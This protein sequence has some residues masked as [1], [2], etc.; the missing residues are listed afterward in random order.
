MNNENQVNNVSTLHF[1]IVL[2]EHRSA[3]VVIIHLIHGQDNYKEKR[4]VITERG[5]HNNALFKIPQQVKIID[6]SGQPCGNPVWHCRGKADTLTVKI[7]GETIKPKTIDSKYI[8]YFIGSDRFD[9]IVEFEYAMKEKETVK[10][11]VGRIHIVRLAVSDRLVKLTADLG[12]DATQV[13]YAI[14]DNRVNP[15]FIIEN[16]MNEYTSRNYPPKTTDSSGAVFVQE[17]KDQPAYFKT[18]NISFKD[19]GY[20]D[21]G[22]ND[23]NTFINYLEVSAA[24][25]SKGYSGGETITIESGFTHKLVNIKMLYAEIGD[26]NNGNVANTVAFGFR[27]GDETKTTLIR[28]PDELIEILRTIYKQIIEVSTKQKDV[29]GKYYSVML[30]VPNIYNQSSIDDLLYYLNDLMNEDYDNGADQDGEK[31]PKENTKLYDFRV[32]SESDS[33]FIGLNEVGDM[34]HSLLEEFLTCKEK[35]TEKKKKDR[36]LIIDSGKGTTD[37]SIINYGGAGNDSANNSI[38]SVK[39][40]GIVG[41]GGAID[42]VIARVFARQIFRHKEEIVSTDSEKWIENESV[43]T[44]RFMNLISSLAPRDQDRFM[45]LNLTLIYPN[46]RFHT[47][48][49]PCPVLS[50]R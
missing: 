48:R 17:E 23:E 40:G 10:K 45:L 22:L 37:Y 39:R 3:R 31:K 15:V 18:G 36:F 21:K 14:N 16:M 32:I 26:N 30:L 24:G 41:A 33:A 7:G 43:F 50:C 1:P 6:T 42:Y 13:N 47:G 25:K 4:V 46:P 29:D 2:G 28:T 27:K 20:I 12:S 38:S 9:G 19:G 8:G 34:E 35:I 5:V 49:C 11:Y 44:E